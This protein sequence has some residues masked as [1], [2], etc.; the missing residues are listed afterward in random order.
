[1]QYL[2]EEHYEIG[3]KNGLKKPTIYR[4]VYQYGWSIK[5]AI[6]K[7]TI[8]RSKRARKHPKE[9]VDLALSNGISLITFYA[10]LKYGWSYEEASTI[11]PK[12]R[13]KR[14]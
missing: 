3:L 4:R 8:N 10:R 14:G 7:P 2:T 12:T 11:K 5:D 6:T 9:I 1:M 13:R